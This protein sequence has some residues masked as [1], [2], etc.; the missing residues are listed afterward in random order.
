MRRM[1]IVVLGLLGISIASLVS[2]QSNQNSLREVADDVK[3]IRGPVDRLF[4]LSVG[5]D[6]PGTLIR[7]DSQSQLKLVTGELGFR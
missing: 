5:S 7:D 6:Y 3:D 2:A 4:D 1:C